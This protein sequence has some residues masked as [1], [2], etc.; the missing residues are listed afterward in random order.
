MFTSHVLTSDPSA[1]AKRPIYR[2]R[3]RLL[4][5]PDYCF[6]VSGLPLSRRLTQRT[7]PII[8]VMQV[9]ENSKFFAHAQHWNTMFWTQ[10]QDHSNFNTAWVYIRA[11]DL[12]LIKKRLRGIHLTGLS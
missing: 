3:P 1:P 2:V 4:Q 8:W 7:L 9:L 5:G 6:A 10:R 12:H 11:P